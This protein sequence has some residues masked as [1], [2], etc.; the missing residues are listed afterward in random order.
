MAALAVRGMTAVDWP[1]VAAISAEGIATRNATFETTVPTWETWIAHM[2][3]LEVM[4]TTPPTDEHVVA[5]T[6]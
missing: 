6:R 4:I 2:L 3:A 5:P 1:R